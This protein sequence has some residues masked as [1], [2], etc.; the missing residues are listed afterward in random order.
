MNVTKLNLIPPDSNY[1]QL[2]NGYNVQSDCLTAKYGKWLA[3]F[4]DIWVE[5]FSDHPMRISFFESII[6]LL[7]DRDFKY[8]MFGDGLNKVAV[9]ES[10]GSLETVDMLRI[11]KN[12]FTRN[13]LNIFSDEIDD[14]LKEPSF[15]V[16]YFSKKT[17]CE[18]CLNCEFESVCKGGDTV[19]RYSVE[20]E[21]DNPSIYCSD[22][23]YI[24]SHV[25]NY[26]HNQI[27]LYDSN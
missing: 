18:S 15:V 9:L 20:K 7:S 4:F 13:G 24:I 3:T 1:E 26:I 21:F 16:H 14:L 8:P 11:S 10:N 25:N 5:E 22:I 27:A 12:G 19:Q 23:K 6:G 17:L 2:P